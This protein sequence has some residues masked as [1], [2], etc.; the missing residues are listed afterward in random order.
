MKCLVLKITESKLYMKTYPTAWPP[1]LL[2]QR[3]ET[4]YLNMLL[5]SREA[6]Q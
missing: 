5:A 2:K 6:S 3:R 1:P 4:V